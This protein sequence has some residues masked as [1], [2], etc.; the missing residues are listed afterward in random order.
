MATLAV[1]SI[2]R[3]GGG[4]FGYLAAAAGGDSFRPGGE[5]FL[6]ILNNGGSSI[7]VTFV[8]PGQAI[9]DLT[10]G[11]LAVSVPAGS[12]RMIGPIRPELFADPSD[13][14]VDITY[15]GV[16]SVFVAAMNLTLP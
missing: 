11:N 16:T 2:S 3:S 7:T 1:N 5:T 4:G 14:L 6:C 10:I 15:S 9:P 8:T 13:G 12:E